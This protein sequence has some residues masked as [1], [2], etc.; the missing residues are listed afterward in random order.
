MTLRVP[1]AAALS[2]L[3]GVVTAQAQDRPT[4]DPAGV[5]G[6]RILMRQDAV[7]VATHPNIGALFDWKTVGV[8]Q[9]KHDVTTA[10]VREAFEDNAIKA[11]R[12]FAEP[13]MVTGTL[14]SVTRRTDRTIIVRLA[15]GGPA[16][17]Q[18]Q[19]RPDMREMNAPQAILDADHANT[20]EQWNVSSKIS[21]LCSKANNVG[22]AVLLEGCIPKD[23]AIAKAEQV[24]DKQA[25]LVL[26]RQPLTVPS[27]QGR[28]GDPAE[29]SLDMLLLGYPLG[30]AA[31]GCS[32]PEDKAWLECGLRKLRNDKRLQADIAQQIRR[33]FAWKIPEPD[34]DKPNGK[35]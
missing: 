31:K 15:E 16:D 19:L 18:R 14:H 12:R 22:L 11:E 13:F 3:A 35:R 25:D 2:A 34:P 33:D 1:L 29:V 10:Q 30:V 32:E 24:A 27:A 17:A 28:A 7:E 8:V 23:T 6:V 5:R 9:P 4:L 20:V 26:A 21:L